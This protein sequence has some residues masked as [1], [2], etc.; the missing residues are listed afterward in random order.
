[1]GK[2]VVLSGTSLK[3]FVKAVQSMENLRLETLTNELKRAYAG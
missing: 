3:A 2:V 1:L